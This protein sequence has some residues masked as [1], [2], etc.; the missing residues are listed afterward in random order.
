MACF[1]NSVSLQGNYEQSMNQ[2]EE[3]IAILAQILAR[4]Y[5]QKKEQSSEAAKRLKNTSRGL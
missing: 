5:C 1:L 2:T 3:K 4:C